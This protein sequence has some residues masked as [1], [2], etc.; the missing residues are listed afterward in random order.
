MEEKRR[1]GT[2]PSSEPRGTNSV[3]GEVSGKGPA[4]GCK[5]TATANR[6]H[7]LFGIERLSLMG[8]HNASD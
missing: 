3:S 6:M 4:F 1:S 8:R 7:S 5:P 2:V